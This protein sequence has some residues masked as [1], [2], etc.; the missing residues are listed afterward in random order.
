MEG[1]ESAATAREGK[2]D[3]CLHG[4]FPNRRLSDL[5]NEV[6][7]S[8]AFTCWLGD[9]QAFHMCKFLVQAGLS[10]AFHLLNP[11][12]STLNQLLAYLKGFLPSNPTP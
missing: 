10:R 1:K 8:H 2:S 3:T 7:L 5:L 9:R 12:P 11:Q 4:E 6:G